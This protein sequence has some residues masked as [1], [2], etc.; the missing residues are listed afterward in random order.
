MGK[1]SCYYDFSFTKKP[2]RFKYQFENPQIKF[3]YNGTEKFSLD[4]KAKTIKINKYP[5]K[6]NMSSLAPLRNSIED[7]SI[8]KTA[9][10]TLVNN[11]TYQL[12]T[13]NLGKRLIQPFGDRFHIVKGK[14]NFIFKIMVD[15][16]N[17]LPVEI[18]RKNDINADFYKVSMRNINTK[19]PTLSKNS[20]Y[21]STYAQEF[22]P[23]KKQERLKPLS[24]GT[25]AP[26]WKLKKFTDNQTLSL[27]DLK[28]KVIL[29]DFWEKNCGA[30]IASV[31]YLKKLKKKFKNQAFELLAINLQDSKEKVERYVKKRQINYPVLL[32]GKNMAKRY[33]VDAFP[34]FFII[35]KSGKVIYGQVGF[36]KATILKIEKIIKKAL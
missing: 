36:D 6:A 14:Y 12:L 22:K 35:D 16:D 4:K 34:T 9:T 17:Y 19:P 5:K 23:A 28:G 27:S 7:N 10:D 29:V 11:H 21:S 33:G 26:D 31:P 30:C 8:T 25:L 15:P 1:W 3:I 2:I 18:T 24:P 13:I 32:N 20:W